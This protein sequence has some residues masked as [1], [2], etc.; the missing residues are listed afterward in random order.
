[1]K[2]PFFTKPPFLAF[3]VCWLPFFANA[4]EVGKAAAA[5]PAAVVPA[6]D[7]KGDKEEM[8]PLPPTGRLDVEEVPK[9]KSVPEDLLDDDH[10]QEEAG[11]SELT[12][13]SIKKVFEDLE[14]LGDL[15]YD[16]LKRALP[17][18]TPADRV[19]VALSLGVLIGDGFLSVQTEKIGDFEDIGRTILKF[20]KVLGAGAKVK[21]R[22]KAILETSDTALGN[23]DWKEL[24]AQ[25]SQTQREVKHEMVLL[26]D[27][28]MV[29]LVSLGGWVRGLQIAAETSSEPFN[30]EKA[31]V[32]TR[33]DVA[34]YFLS[35]LES[36]PPAT[37]KNP[38]IQSLR[39]SLAEVSKLVTL[40]EGKPLSKEE[41]DKIKAQAVK[42]LEVCTKF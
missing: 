36:M 9:A 22:V 31:K 10:V 33:A 20:A 8:K 41:V 7:G 27:I 32:L 30:A 18:G 19:T 11:V 25:L 26:R 34:E 12:T 17:Q 14:S 42:M 6:A 40:P 35:T 39:E 1:M 15:P 23:L 5:A 16:R 4:Q 21:E 13:P 3:A 28:D 38:T 29:H 37:L 2:L 24:K